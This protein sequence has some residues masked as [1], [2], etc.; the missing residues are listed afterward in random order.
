M[1]VERGRKKSDTRR[2]KAEDPAGVCFSQAKPCLLGWFGA[3]T[4]EVSGALNP[5][6]LLG[7]VGK[8]VQEALGVVPRACVV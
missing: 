3:P 5:F 7:V 1:I 6:L 8:G 4:V 2:W